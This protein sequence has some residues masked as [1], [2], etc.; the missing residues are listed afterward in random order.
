MSLEHWVDNHS[1]VRHNTSPQEIT[2]LFAIADRDLHD[3]KFV[4]ISP[5]WRH[6]IAYNAALQLAK[7]ALK[8]LLPNPPTPRHHDFRHIVTFTSHLLSLTH[9][10]FQPSL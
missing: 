3:C 4:D 10:P 6:N 1:L 7:A 9:K 8:P 5:D 2:D